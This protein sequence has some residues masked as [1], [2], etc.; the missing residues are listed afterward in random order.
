MSGPTIPEYA[1]HAGARYKLVGP[2]IP[3]CRDQAGAVTKE[4]EALYAGAE[5]VRAV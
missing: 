2:T 4:P 3:G 5:L 1:L